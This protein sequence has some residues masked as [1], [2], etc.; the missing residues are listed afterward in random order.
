MESFIHNGK[1]IKFWPVSGI[2]L[3]T[4]KHS[5]T[6][7]KISSSGGGGTVGPSGGYVSPPQISSESKSVTHH[8]IWIKTDDGT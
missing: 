1:V 7:V 2:V 4:E 8:E 3:S 6:H 5:E